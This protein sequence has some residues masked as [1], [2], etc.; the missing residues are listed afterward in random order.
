ME[1]LSLWRLASGWCNILR[2]LMGYRV[3]SRLCYFLWPWLVLDM[4]LYMSLFCHTFGLVGLGQCLIMRTDRLRSCI[5]CKSH[6]LGKIVDGF[7]DKV[8]FSRI[9]TLVVLQSS[10]LAK[11]SLRLLHRLPV[12]V[13]VPMEVLTLHMWRIHAV[14]LAMNSSP[15]QLFE[16][17]K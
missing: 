1:G 5:A 6:L 2:R 13:F 17:I 15:L 9:H 14:Q 10:Y 7:S 12:L 3:E 16:L 11:W 4:S 8:V